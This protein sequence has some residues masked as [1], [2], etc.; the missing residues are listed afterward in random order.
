MLVLG[1][2]VS[3]IHADLRREREPNGL[4]STAQPLVPPSTVGGVVAA[5]GDIDTYAIAAR[6]GQTIKADILARGFRAAS[7]PGSQLSAVLE[8][9]GPDGLTVLA[10][11]E[12]QGDFDDPAVSA[13]VGG[14]GTYYIT[15]RDLSPLEGSSAYVYLLSVEIDPNDS[16]D[17]A[18]PILPPVMPSIDALIYPPGDID[19]YRFEG[20]A[21]QVVTVEVDSAVFNPVQPPAKI[22]LTLLAPDGTM[23]AQDAYTSSDP[24]DPFIQVPLPQDGTYT[25]V[26]RE[27]RAFIGTTNTFYQM[28]VE[29]GPAIG[30]DTFGSGMPVTLPRAVSGVISPAT[31]ADHNRFGL[32]SSASVRADLDAREGLLSLLQGTLTLNDAT[33]MVA[34]DASTPDPLLVHAAGPGDFS[35]AVQGPCA[36]SGCLS[37]DAYFVL[38]LDDDADGDG[39]YLPDDNCPL[40]ANPNQADDDG[41]GV[42]NLCDNCPS[43]FNPDQGDADHDGRGDACPGCDPP[44]E[45]ASGLLFLDGRSLVWPE[46][47]TAT[48][49][50]LYRGTV[51]GGAWTYDQACLQGSLPI[52]AAADDSLP[53]AG[54]AFYYLVGAR[55]SCG[56]GG[57]GVDSAGDPRPNDAAC[58]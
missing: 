16:S 13:P 40:R 15:V 14:D 44:A 28:S 27:L 37:Q 42:G 57:L 29:L 2:A 7:G 19:D 43:I 24:N 6:A 45:V 22:V 49:Y 32:G 33:G 53:G 41:D 35:V 58:P 38:F 30:N 46:E 5:P 23:L 9:L 25:I 56:E 39:L 17:V 47:T 31:D 51:D 1:I 8:I 21:G 12:S 48:S 52:A 3:S 10:H 54:T 34:S 20:L 4:P 55:N 50:S 11:G 36:G 18:T 26:V